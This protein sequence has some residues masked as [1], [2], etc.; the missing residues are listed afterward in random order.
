MLQERLP[1]H[2][3]LA[4]ANRK[5]QLD[6]LEL[7]RLITLRMLDGITRDYFFGVGFF[8]VDLIIK[9]ISKLQPTLDKARLKIG[10]ISCLL[11]NS[12]IH[13]ANALLVLI[14]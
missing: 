8:W 4:K 10:K 2:A 11:I 9:P 13:L 3:L 6:Y 1:K 14:Y 5:I 12:V 7:N